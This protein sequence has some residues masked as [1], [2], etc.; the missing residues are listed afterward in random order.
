MC[1]SGTNFK[2]EN[3]TFRKL[4]GN[5]LTYNIPRFQRDYS[6]TDVEWD[7][8]WLDIQDATKPDGEPAHYMGYLVLQTQNDKTFDVIDGQ[9]RLT[10][11]SIIVLAILRNLKR[12]VEAGKDPE[13]NQQRLDQ[14]RSSYIGYLDPVTLVA[15]SKLTLN[16]NNNDYYQTYLV[17]LA[18]LPQRGFKASEHAMRK[19]SDWFEKRVL[20][21]AN[22]ATDADTSTGVALAKLL[23]SICD[24]LFFTVITVS[25]ELNAYK[26]FE[27]L[28]SRGVRLS[29]TD[30][31]KNYLFSVLHR[32][33]VHENEMS[34]MDDRW[35]RL[36]SRLGE[37]D[38]P[39]F[40]RIHWMSRNGLVRQSELFKT[41]RAKIDKRAE[42]FALLN[43]L[44]ADVDPYL[45]LI[46]PESSDWS[47]E[48]KDSAALLRMFG[49]RQPY[50][51]LIA[52]RRVLNANDFTALLRIIVNISFRYN[53][54]GTMQAGEQERVYSDVAARLSAGTIADLASIIE[55]LR[56]V[57]LGDAG[58]KAA[59]ASKELKTTQSRNN[60]IM[61][62]ILCNLERQAGGADHDRDSAT[63]TV[64]H[65]LPQNPEGGWNQFSEIETDANIY[66][67]GNM[68][69]L[70][71]TLNRDIGN[72][73]YGVKR[74]AFEGSMFETTKKI[75]IDNDEWT[76]QRVIARQNA[77]AKV[78]ISIWRVAQ[79]S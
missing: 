76:P 23:E 61:R 9:Q 10:T 36:V 75:A 65:I 14:I 50:A 77:M 3:N 4:F 78:A 2:T 31:L 1:M 53:V 58:F 39:D 41:I 27:T 8:L 11:L 7:E 51:L 18:A 68:A 79:L 29:A 25:D 32:D 21:F 17:P 22:A 62:Y 60:R 72:A 52:A 64:E 66:R 56:P 12:L 67:I 47:P 26:V 40:L 71:T 13:Q 5:G 16:R 73:A 54:I 59:F 34:A 15:A 69:L 45:G 43:A 38:L 70:E 19:A 74:A 20:E 6:W 55:A 48:L 42:V 28:N 44:D 24:K 33:T 63:F 46:S 30:L 37:T 49:V 57:Y 35:E